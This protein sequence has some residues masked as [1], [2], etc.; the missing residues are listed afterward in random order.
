MK[1]ES[2]MKRESNTSEHPED[3]RNGMS[4]VN[5][6]YDTIGM[7]GSSYAD[8]DPFKY[9]DDVKL[10][11]GFGADEA[12]LHR[13]YCDPNIKA[14]PNYDKVN[15]NERYTIPS[16]PDEGPGNHMALQGDMEFRMKERESKGFLTR[17]RIP[18]E[19]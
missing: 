14:L 13:G 6:K 16:Q 8:P 2:Y 18:T 19:R 10:F 3:Y 7:L 1:F 5:P 12:D 11:A 4:G 9:P 17:P 15:Y